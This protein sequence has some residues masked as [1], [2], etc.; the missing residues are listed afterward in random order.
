MQYP[1]VAVNAAIF[2]S[3]HRILLTL[4]A[5]N[6]LWCLPGGIVE[7]NETVEDA[8][9]R[10]LLEEIGVSCAH[11]RLVGIYSSNNLNETQVTSRP[12]IIV[13][14][15]CS[16]GARTP[17]TSE[18]VLSFAYFNIRDLPANTITSHVS[19]IRDAAGNGRRRVIFHGYRD[20]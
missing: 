9:R 6:H 13:L 18:E 12:S 20:R 3:H 11:W 8:L 10:E 15:R 16:I 7:Y 14:F 5:D 19:R 4:R 2:C 17:T 1:I